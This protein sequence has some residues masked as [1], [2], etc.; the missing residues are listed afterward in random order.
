MPQ[1]GN[2]VS[3]YPESTHRRWMNTNEK[4]E[5]FFLIPCESV[6]KISILLQ[7]AY[8][9]PWQF[10][11]NSFLCT[12]T[13]TLTCGKKEKKNFVEIQ[14]V[15]SNTCTVHIACHVTY[16]YLCLTTTIL[17]RKINNRCKK[18]DKE[19]KHTTI[20]TIFLLLP[21]LLLLKK[22]KENVLILSFTTIPMQVSRL[23]PA[24]SPRYTGKSG[25]RGSC[26][27]A[28]VQIQ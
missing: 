27:E 15:A 3:E 8:F 25:K 26:K 28:L 22:K 6:S 10:S 13:T 19:E 11:P 2:F 1:K 23:C 17:Q 9:Q 12:P 4:W 24:Q 20:S 21:L 16:F 5:F 18:K 14:W 7:Y